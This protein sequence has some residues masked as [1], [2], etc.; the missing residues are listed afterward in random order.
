MCQLAACVMLR[1]V[2]L[3]LRSA[4]HSELSTPRRL[5][6]HMHGCV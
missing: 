1:A 6:Q 3:A 5:Q 2:L 4:K